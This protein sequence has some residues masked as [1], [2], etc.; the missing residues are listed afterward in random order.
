M[1]DEHKHGT[2]DITVQ[3]KTFSGFVRFVTWSVILILVFLVFLA[4]VNG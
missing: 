3:E 4:M 2:M 1:A